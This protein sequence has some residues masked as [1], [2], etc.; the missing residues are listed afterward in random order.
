METSVVH[1]EGFAHVR[2]IIGMILGL[3]L[4]RLVN[5]L[6]RFVQHPGKVQI[7]PI[8]LAWVVFLLISIV[9][10]WWYE[11]HLSLVRQWTFPIYFFLIVYTMMFAA[12]TALL[13]PDQMS[14][15]TGFEHYFESSKRWFYGL[16]ALTFL[17]DVGDTLIKGKDYFLSLGPEYPVRQA[18]FFCLSVCAIFIPGKRYQAIFVTAA[19]FY[20][21]TWILR[22]YDL[23]Q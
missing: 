18:V 19:I 8:H 20:L 1:I 6:T 12:L 10:F 2:T 4:A 7:Y 22:S 17:V 14:D 21:V 13:F 11:F 16:L 9:H 23:L 15:Y 5:G 3:S